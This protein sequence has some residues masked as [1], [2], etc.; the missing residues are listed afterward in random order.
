MAPQSIVCERWRGD[1][2]RPLDFPPTSFGVEVSRPRFVQEPP[3]RVVFSNSTGAKVPCAVSGYPRPSVTWYSHQG[4]ALAASVGGSDA[5]PSVVANGLRRVLPDGSLAFRAFSEREYAPELHHATY[6]CSA[7]NAVGTLVSRDVKVRAVVLEEFEAHVH[8]DYVPRGNTA[9]F[10]CH[11]P[12]TLRQ[13]LSVTSWTTED[14]LVIGRRETHLPTETST[15]YRVTSDGD[16]CV[17]GVT[18]ASDTRHRFRC[19]VKHR[20][21]GDVRPSVSAGS[22]FITEPSGKSAPRIL[23]AQASV[24]TSPGEDAEVP[25]LARG[26]PPPSTRW[27]RRSSR[28]L[29][30]VA[31]RPGTVHLPGLLVLRSAV[32]SDQGRYTCLANNSVGE[33]R[34]DTELLV[35]LNVSVTVSPE[36]ARA[37]LTRPMTFNCTARG[38]RGGALSFSWLHDGSVP[39]APRFQLRADG[40]RLHLTSVQREDVGVY[41]CFV[42][43]GDA[44]AQGSAQLRLHGKRFAN[45]LVPWTTFA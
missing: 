20:L 28:G 11:V 21:T 41:Q 45:T 3:S 1:A 17:F 32:E 26:H 12:S 5:G 4:H 7:T 16:L 36:E 33:D 14:G 35:R 6:R 23:K 8:D 40:Q 31:S 18:G 9:L 13:Y 44:T 38:F 42:R 43:Y 39:G 22:L 10:R 25:C 30:P 34:M 24:E 15:K 37:E 19:H 29:T 27:F 2:R